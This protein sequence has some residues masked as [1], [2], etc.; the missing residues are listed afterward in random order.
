[1]RISPVGSFHEL[2]SPFGRPRTACKAGS[3]VQLEGG[4]VTQTQLSHSG[5][6]LRATCSD[7]DEN[8]MPADGR[9]PFL[10]NWS[11]LLL[12]G[13][14]STHSRPSAPKASSLLR[15]SKPSH[16]DCGQQ[17]PAGSA[18][19][20]C[21]PAGESP[22]GGRTLASSPPRPPRG[23]CLESSHRAS[24]DSSHFLSSGFRA[25]PRC[26]SLRETATARLARLPRASSSQARCFPS[27]RDPWSGMCPFSHGQYVS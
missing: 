27:V 3:S 17:P 5:A 18:A 11:I 21:S 26:H 9:S 2:P 23:S 25:Q 1:M 14:E 22:S 12:G 7:H 13:V 20:T 24:C 10:K 19:R 8:M 16:P 6:A 4:R 15:A